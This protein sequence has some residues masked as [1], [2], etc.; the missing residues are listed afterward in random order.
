MGNKIINLVEENFYEW[1]CSTGHLLPR[2][3]RELKRF[4]KLYPVGSI[5]INENAIDP[6]SIILGTRIEKRLSINQSFIVSSEPQELKMAAR[7]FDGLPS[8]ILDQ[9]KRNQKNNK[10]DINDKS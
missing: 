6:L 10:D 4:E 3:E 7:K 1:L 9:I 2:N 8:D 5:D